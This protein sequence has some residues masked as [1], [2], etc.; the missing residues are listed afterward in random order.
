MDVW[1]TF[2][3]YRTIARDNSLHGTERA[4]RIWRLKIVHNATN[5]V[6]IFFPFYDYHERVQVIIIKLSNY[7][8]LNPNFLQSQNPLQFRYKI[9][10]IRIFM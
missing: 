1:A 9:N 10:E 5:F 4:E 7:S 6:L 2:L 3:G 8:H